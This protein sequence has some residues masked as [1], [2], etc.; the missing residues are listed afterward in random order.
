MAAEPEAFVPKEQASALLRLALTLPF[1]KSTVG[2]LHRRGT[3]FIFGGILTLETYVCAE[4]PLLEPWRGW[5][6]VIWRTP[7]KNVP[8]SWRKVPRLL[9]FPGK[10]RGVGFVHEGYRKNWKGN[11]RRT[12][13]LHERREI[14]ITPATLSEFGQAYHA[15]GHLDPFLRY[16]MLK[17]TKDHLR[18]HPENVHIIL[19][20]SK[21]RIAGGAIFVDFPDIKSS[22]YIASF[23]NTEGRREAHGYAFI[24]WWYKH[25]L[26]KGIIWADFG[27]MWQH[28]DPLEWRGSSSFKKHFSPASH[29]FT[30]YWK[31]G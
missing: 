20:Y 1:A 30:S 10:T 11:S 9:T 6:F 18:V 22:S 14:G 28:G 15:S 31:A 23:L 3:R 13:E 7:S 25:M 26:A 5:R 19:T 27:I 21:N 4:E 16:G 8:Q 24:D 29:T 17:V 2:A 12:A